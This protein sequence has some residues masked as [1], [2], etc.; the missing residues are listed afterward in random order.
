[1]E[2]NL[3][4]ILTKNISRLDFSDNLLP[5]KEKKSKGM[6]VSLFIFSGENLVQVQKMCN[7]AHN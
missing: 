6:L 1:M 4:Q 7:F 2:T 3:K 5:F